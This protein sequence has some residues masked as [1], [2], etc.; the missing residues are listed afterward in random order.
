MTLVL[1]CGSAATPEPLSESSANGSRST[2]SG[3]PY[4]N[5]SIWR[6]PPLLP[7]APRRPLRKHLAPWTAAFA[8][9]VSGARICAAPTALGR[10]QSNL[11][12]RLLGA[13]TERAAPPAGANSWPLSQRIEARDTLIG[14]SDHDYPESPPHRDRRLRLLRLGHG[15]PPEA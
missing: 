1:R 2:T 8:H 4:K 10:R 11:K 3:R 9:Q 5:S 7:A 12:Q 15:R 6:G 14:A 13:G